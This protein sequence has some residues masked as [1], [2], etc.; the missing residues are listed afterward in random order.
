[1]NRID[2]VVLGGP[3]DGREVVIAKG[4]KHWVYPTTTGGT[5]PTEVER[6]PVER[7]SNGKWFAVYPP[8]HKKIEEAK[9]RGEQWP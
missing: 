1:M 8:L 4:A 2:A 7:N 6:Y 5:F 3:M 9:S